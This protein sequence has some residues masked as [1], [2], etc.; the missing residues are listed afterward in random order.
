[1]PPVFCLNHAFSGTL[2]QRVQYLCQNRQGKL[3][4]WEYDATHHD[5]YT[6]HTSEK[7]DST[8]G[9][10]F[11][12]SG[13]QLFHKATLEIQPSIRAEKSPFVIKTQNTFINHE[14][15]INDIWPI[16]S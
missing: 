2:L 12:I 6:S 1:M 14:E 4:S 9:S 15:H 7:I 3:H 11:R 16:Y 5:R 10:V 8:L 13:S